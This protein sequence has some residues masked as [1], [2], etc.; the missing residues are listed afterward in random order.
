M[1]TGHVWFST[2]VRELLQIAADEKLDSLDDLLSR[3][4]RDD[5]ARV[6]GSIEGHVYSR[7]GHDEEFRLRLSTGEYHWFRGRGQAHWAEAGTPIRMVGSIQDIHDRHEA[8]AALARVKEQLQQAL[9]GGNVGMWDWNILTDEVSVSPELML[10]LGEDPGKPWTTLEDWSDRLHPDDAEAAKRRTWEY[11][12]G[13]TDEYES[14]FR[15]RHV[16]GNY[17]W[18][19]SRGRLFRSEDGQPGRLIGVHVDVTELREVQKALE[20]SEAKFRGIF[21]Q[22]FQFIGVLDPDG[23]IV[24][25]NRTA[26]EA[27][28]VDAEQVIGHKFWDTAWWSHSP[29][30]QQRLKNAIARAA[31]GDF[32]R[33]EATHPTHD[34]TIAYV[35]F[36]VKPVTDDSGKVVYLIPEGRDISELKMFEQELLSRTAELESSNRELEQFAYVASHDLQEP[37]RTVIGFC[38][39]LELE[40]K[41]R[42]EGDGTMY[43]DT[44]VQGGKRMQQL[45]TDLLEYSRV[46]RRGKPFEPVDLND[47]MDNVVA[48]LHSSIVESDA[49]IEYGDLPVVKADL[50]QMTRLLQNVVGN[51]LKYRGN[52]SPRV[53]IWTKETEQDLFLYISD[54]GIGIKKEFSEQIFII[55]RRLHTREEYPGTG[56]GLAIC[57]RIVERHGG[58]IRVV[59]PDSD[60]EDEGTTFEI[61]LSKDP[62]DNFPPR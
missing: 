17:R 43:L 7:K 46:G 10:Q 55:F 31:G 24:D 51:S 59:P 42:L 15:L 44:I 4:H 50:G 52:A 40:Y 20:V 28:G 36:S 47:V 45:I 25:A 41:D 9:E 61:V 62:T 13:I 49:V 21:N 37:L 5:L 27:A 58:S 2:R 18:I 32:D 22:T 60:N 16:D 56:I 29:A 8:Q 12:E 57:R 38:Q 34:G 54:N 19:L 3:V 23:E 11:I 6:R 26:L 30:L 33:F 39:L 1:A 35:D 53:K 14:S 48:L